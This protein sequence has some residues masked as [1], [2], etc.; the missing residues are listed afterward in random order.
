MPLLLLPRPTTPARSG[1]QHACRAQPWLPRRPYQRLHLAP[2][3]RRNRPAA[4]LSIAGASHQPRLAGPSLGC[5]VSELSAT[6]LTAAAQQLRREAG[7]M[8]ETQRAALRRM[9]I[10]LFGLPA[11]LGAGLAAAG[12]WVGKTRSSAQA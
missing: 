3:L 1:W 6:N 11:A 7:T 9:A 5:L 12:T 4:E 8:P 2:S 10:W